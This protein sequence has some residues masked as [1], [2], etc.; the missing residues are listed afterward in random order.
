MTSK[1]RL[2]KVLEEKMAEPE[3]L[4]LPPSVFRNM[5]EARN[6]WYES[7]EEVRTALDAAGR[8]RRRIEWLREGLRRY[9]TPR[10]RRHLELHFVCGFS[11]SQVAVMTRTSRSSAHRTIHRALEALRVILEQREEEFHRGNDPARAAR[12]VRR[13]L[14]RQR[15]RVAFLGHPLDE[16]VGDQGRPAG[17]VAGAEPGAGVAVEEF[18]E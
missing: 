15:S 17:L 14:R 9:L 6:P 8:R 3:E 1:E 10:E 7:R 12:R 13:A 4:F 5:A 16:E 18:V 11:L 2:K